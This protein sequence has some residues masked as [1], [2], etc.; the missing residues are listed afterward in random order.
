MGNSGSSSTPEIVTAT[1][2]PNILQS[3]GFNND[4]YVQSDP[5]SSGDLSSAGL[6]NIFGSG[7]GSV[8]SAPIESRGIKTFNGSVPNVYADQYA[9]QPSKAPSKLFRNRYP[10]TDT[11]RPYTPK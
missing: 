4:T 3:G 10:A 8:P 5:W 9:N 1:F 7:S 6:G 2:S 11:F